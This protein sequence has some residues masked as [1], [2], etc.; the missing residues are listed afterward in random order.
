MSM[1]IV[2]HTNIKPGEL[3]T[4]AFKGIR[5]LGLFFFISKV[6]VRPVMG[7]ESAVTSEWKLLRRMFPDFLNIKEQD[8]ANVS[9]DL[10]ARRGMKNRNTF[11][12]RSRWICS[13]W[14]AAYDHEVLAAAHCKCLQTSKECESLGYFSCSPP[15]LSSLRLLILQS[16]RLYLI[17]SYLLEHFQMKLGRSFLW[18]SWERKIWIQ[19][20]TYK[21][22]LWRVL[23]N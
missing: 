11:L 10:H 9:C 23:H 22:K 21:I 20:H 19:G 6:P 4:S 13:E 7:S 1:L 5:K 2:L 8:D 12:R 15:S 17:R 14:T 18:S 16:P 3:R